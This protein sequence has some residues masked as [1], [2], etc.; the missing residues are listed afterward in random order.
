[1]QPVSAASGV[2][3]KVG[4]MDIDEINGGLTDILIP[5]A[6]KEKEIKFKKKKKGKEK[7]ER[8]KKQKRGKKEKK[9]KRTEKESQQILS[10]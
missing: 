3:V 5:W 4:F 10:T 7:Q 1:M 2:Q 6:P 9:K 8:K